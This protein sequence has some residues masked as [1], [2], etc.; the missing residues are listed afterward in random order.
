MTTK[1]IAEQ[2][3][4]KLALLLGL[5]CSLAVLPS[6]LGDYYLHMAMLSFSAMLLGLGH[7]LLYLTGQASYGH[8]AFYALGAYVTAIGTTSAGMSAWSSLLLAAILPGIVAFALSAVAFRTRGAYFVLLSFGIAVVV[9]SLLTSLKGFT[10][11]NSGIMNIPPLTGLSSVS[12]H[13]YFLGGV[14][15]A[16]LSSFIIL[17]RSRWILELR[18]IGQS[19]NLAASVGIPAQSNMT[20]A[21]IVGASI[22]G[23]LGG[24]FASYTTFVSPAAHTFWTSI[25]ILTFTVVGGAAYMM[26]P[27]VGAAYITLVP[28]LFNWSQS[29]VGMFVAASIAAVMLVV[30]EGIVTTTITRSK[31][32][33]EQ[34]PVAD[35]VA[36]VRGSDADLIER[37]KHAPGARRG[38]KL[39]VVGLSHSFGGLQTTKDVT[40]SAAPGECLGII[41]PN[42]AGKTTLFN[43]ISGFVPAKTGD[44]FLD[45]QR[46]NG[47]APERV[48]QLGLT[49]TFQSSVAFEELSVFENVLLGAWGSQTSIPIGERYFT[50]RY[51]DPE[52][53]GR[54]IDTIELF[55][56]SAVKDVKAR[57]LPYGLKKLLG[58]AVGFAT[59]PSVLCLDEPVAGMTN[60]EV[61][62][63]I[64][65]LKVIR[66]SF[67]TTM[68]LVEHRMPVVMGVCDRIIVLNFGEVIATGTPSEVS[69]NPLVHE[70]Y[71]GSQ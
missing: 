17:E 58:L 20:L 42:G 3:L 52:W 68:L 46:L 29:L 40:F 12:H 5:A 41:G 63:M 61:E 62:R 16:V 59:R 67:G 11:G 25:F 49:R 26:G 15:I 39:D 6:F 55:G 53:H 50:N 54:V 47:L 37:L 9:H 45:G 69:Q 32:S 1:S 27:I 18:S 21:L 22:A 70:V 48:Q 56:L 4:M 64:S 43:L 19:A 2:P 7:R 23:A 35:E 65:T 44:L 34:T 57:E 60:A 31:R 38:G 71:F 10:G 28:L 66:K 13:Y 33:K 36:D 51:R 14:F 30:P 24:I 8:G